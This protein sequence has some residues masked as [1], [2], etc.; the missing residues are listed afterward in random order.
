MEQL[1]VRLTAVPPGLKAP[2]SIDDVLEALCELDGDPTIRQAARVATA[3][4]G[5]SM[6]SWRTS[7]R[8]KPCWWLRQ[9]EWS[10]RT[11]AAFRNFIGAQ[12]MPNGRRPRFFWW[13]T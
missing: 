9:K 10:A 5:S 1:C 13:L 7:A 4:K 8:T 12:P 2:V 6:I 3:A 11:S